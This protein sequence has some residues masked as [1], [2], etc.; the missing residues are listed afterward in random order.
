MS[1]QLD[2]MEIPDSDDFFN[3][4]MSESSTAVSI[5]GSTDALDTTQVEHRNE[6]PKAPSAADSSFGK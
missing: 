2:R 5:K 4:S 3:D 6:Q 1:F